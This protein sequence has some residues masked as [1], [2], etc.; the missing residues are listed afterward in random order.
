MSSEL[1]LNVATSNVDAPSD[2]RL[3]GKGKHGVLCKL[4]RVIHA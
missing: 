4:N 2:E 3:R 1:Q